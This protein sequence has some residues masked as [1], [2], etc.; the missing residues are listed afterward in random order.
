MSNLTFVTKQEYLTW[1]ADWRAAYAVLSGEIRREKHA[2]KEA[3]RARK[4]KSNH[5]HSLKVIATVTLQER[6]A[7]KERA[8]EMYL[9]RRNITLVVPCE[10]IAVHA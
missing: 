9:Q 2:N 8:Q 6:Q 1:R 5:I 7:S 4:C 3:D 10:S